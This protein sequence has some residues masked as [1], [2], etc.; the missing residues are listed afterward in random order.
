ML[1]EF[2]PS[3][4]GQPWAKSNAMEHQMIIDFLGYFAGGNR[5]ESLPANK[6]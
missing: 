6:I 5:P 1:K 3:K 4:S 2:R